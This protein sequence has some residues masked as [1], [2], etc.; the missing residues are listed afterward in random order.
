MD[1]DGYSWLI[2]GQPEIIE[3]VH[4]E[5]C[6]KVYELD[7]GEPEETAAGEEIITAD[8]TAGEQAEAEGTNETEPTITEA[9]NTDEV[10]HRRKR[11]AKTLLN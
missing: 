5:N 9:E 11:T 4:D 10:T 8:E 3:H 1:E 2:C 7:D 6:F